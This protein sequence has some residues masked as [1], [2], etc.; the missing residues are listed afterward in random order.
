M[1][2]HSPLHSVGSCVVAALILAVPLGVSA[3]GS[4][5]PPGAPAPTMKTLAQIEPRNAISALPVTI[6]NAGSY[7]LTTNLTGVSA[8]HGITVSASDVTLDLNGFSLIGVAGA[9]TGITS[10]APALALTVRNGTLRNWPGGA[11]AVAGTDARFESLNVYSN[12]TSFAITAGARAQLRSSSLAQNAAGVSLGPGGAVSD[13]VIRHNTGTGLLTGEGSL[14]RH[15]VVF[16]NAGNGVVL[17]NGS[18]LQ[19][20]IVR[21]NGQNGVVALTN[22]SLAHCNIAQ[23]FSNG[24]FLTIGG[25]ITDCTISSNRVDGIRAVGRCTITGNSLDFNGLA[26]RDAGIRLLDT[27]S[28]VEENNITSHITGILSDFGFNLI[29]RNKATLNDTNFSFRAE[30]IAG[31]ASTNATTAGPWA[32]FAY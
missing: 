28:R 18:S 30:D 17:G 20:G 27:D 1:K 12:G 3:Q 13:C 32:N 8:S 25:R 24:V 15:C 4:L 7:Y 2:A 14:V 29:V 16:G 10:A 6:S 22:A 23:N 26:G 21:T 31:A 11:I 9:L 19:G 5:T